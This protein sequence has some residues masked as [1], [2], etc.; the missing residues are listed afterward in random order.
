MAVKAKHDPIA[1]NSA[2]F[3]SKND[4]WSNH[5]SRLATSLLLSIAPYRFTFSISNSS[6][7]GDVVQ[8]I[9]SQAVQPNLHFSEMI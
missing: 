4:L 1:P 6:I 3:Q 8:Y 9:W 2:R 7:L 5:I